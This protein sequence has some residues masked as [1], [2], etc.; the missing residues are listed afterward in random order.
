MDMD[1]AHG[2]KFA[3]PNRQGGLFSQTV[4]EP[5]RA[6]TQTLVSAPRG[7]V[8]CF[9]FS[10]LIRNYPRKPLLLKKHKR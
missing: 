5:R 6:R 3:N 7:R 10:L 9:S 1:M 2:M 4:E 8:F